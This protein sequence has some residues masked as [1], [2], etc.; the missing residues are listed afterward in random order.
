MRTGAWQIAAVLMS[1]AGLAAAAEQ[2]GPAQQSPAQQSPAQQSEKQPSSKEDSQAPSERL[3]ALIRVLDA[4]DFAEREKAEREIVE[5]RE[6]AS[7]ELDRALGARE[8]L[9]PEGRVRLE[10]TG[11]LRFVRSPRAAM[12]ISFDE[13]NEQVVIASALEGFESATVFKPGD[14]LRT[15][16]GRAVRS[17]EDARA[18]IVSF[19]PGER[20]RVRFTRQ[21]EERTAWIT[22]GRFDRL[23]ARAPLDSVVMLRAWSMRLERIDAR[24]GGGREPGGAVIDARPEGH[25]AQHVE[26][27][28]AEGAMIGEGAGVVAG[29]RSRTRGGWTG[30]ETGR[31][32][33]G[34]FDAGRAAIELGQVGEQI[35]ARR[36]RIG[37]LERQA[38]D[39]NIP[40]EARQRALMEA[41]AL[42]RDLDQLEQYRQRLLRRLQ[43]P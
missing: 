32:P 24:A 30:V 33:S 29:G 13:A 41:D 10:R 27:P 21:G 2:P 28:R 40:A 4:G 43:R 7:A 8:A 14:V 36:E 16:A 42:R 12:G 23:E 22:L 37:S 34:G 18:V 35:R 15:V 26:Y 39:A 3:G 31:R 11:W 20:V 1:A 9:S 17:L 25:G 38:N 6:L 5:W 19:E